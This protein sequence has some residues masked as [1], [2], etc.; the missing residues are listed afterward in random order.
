MEVNE[1]FVLL[2]EDTEAIISLFTAQIEEYVTD[3]L[4]YKIC[5]SIKDAEL[6]IQ[7][8]GFPILAVCD[9]DLGVEDSLA[10]TRNLHNANPQTLLI[11][12]S[13]NTES[14]KK[15]LG[16]GCTLE[17]TNKSEIIDLVH[18]ILT[19]ERKN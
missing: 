15:L 5:T 17:V 10:F 12:S 9:F 3:G 14:R 11:A 2:L 1:S 13:S 4:R 6:L 19:S 8:E 18:S 7:E 16:A